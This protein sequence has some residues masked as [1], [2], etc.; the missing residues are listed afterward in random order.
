MA[1]STETKRESIVVG[2][3]AIPAALEWAALLRPTALQ[4]DRKKEPN[5]ATGFVCRETSIF[6]SAVPPSVA[7]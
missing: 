2:S 6:V 1:F 5:V 4:R 3:F 7:A